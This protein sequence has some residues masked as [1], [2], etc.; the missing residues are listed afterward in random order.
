MC[1]RWP[2]VIDTSNRTP[3]FLRYQ[4]TNY[5]NALMPKDM[6]PDVIRM[7][8]LGAI[9]YG[10]PFVLDMMEVDMFE[11]A[12]RIMDE[13]LPNLMEMIMDKSI[14]LEEK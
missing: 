14:L 11:T 1:F 13:V 2:M 8:V 10:K 7:G 5:I 3:T 4:D 9:R 6:V 12:T